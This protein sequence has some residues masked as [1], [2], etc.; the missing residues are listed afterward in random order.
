MLTPDELYKLA[1]AYITRRYPT[2]RGAWREDLIQ[3]YVIAGWKSEKKLDPNRQPTHSAYQQ[4]CGRI[5][6][7]HAMT[8]RTKYHP[9]KVARYSSVVYSVFAYNTFRTLPEQVDE[10]TDILIADAIKRLPT[11]AK[12]VILFRISGLTLSQI[13]EVL[14]CHV[15]TV[16][17]DLLRSMNT[18]RQIIGANK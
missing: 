2:I 18:I 1:S 5:A 6:V 9:Y 10:E 16:Q 12:S 7:H 4:K 3:E 11:R 14:N 8:A 13:A 17:K 15:M